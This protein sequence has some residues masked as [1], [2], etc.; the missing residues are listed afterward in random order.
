MAKQPEDRRV[1]DVIHRDAME[2]ILWWNSMTEGDRAN[3]MKIAGSAVP[4]EAWAAYQRHVK[5]HLSVSD[6]VPRKD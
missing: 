6:A 3:W 1:S 4:A 2:G 5:Q